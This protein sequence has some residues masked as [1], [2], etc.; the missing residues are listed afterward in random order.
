MALLDRSD[1]WRMSRSGP[2]LLGG[3]SLAMAATV[4]LVGAAIGST[5]VQLVLALLAGAAIIAVIT[6][7]WGSSPKQVTI[8]GG[9][10]ALAAFGGAV[11]AG[12]VTNAVLTGLLGGV[13]APVF[14]IGLLGIGSTFER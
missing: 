1:T 11:L 7:L 6:V 13:L 14:L 3:I 5:I 10:M 2:L 9:A 4:G 8:L 12:V